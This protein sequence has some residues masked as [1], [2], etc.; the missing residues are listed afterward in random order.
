LQVR[1]KGMAAIKKWCT[2]VQQSP[3]DQAT[4]DAIAPLVLQTICTHFHTIIYGAGADNTPEIRQLQ[5]ESFDDCVTDGE[6]LEVFLTAI[7]RRAGDGDM[8]QDT[9]DIRE[10]VRV[11]IFMHSCALFVIYCIIN[12][13][14]VICCIIIA[15]FAHT[16]AIMHY[17]SFNALFVH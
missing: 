4:Y 2:L 5:M 1:G 17:L 8:I 11:M 7:E 9:H 16:H 14:F 6:S 13:L 15:L 12:A 10:K 3:I